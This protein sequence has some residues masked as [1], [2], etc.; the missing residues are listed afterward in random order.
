MNVKQYLE[1]IGRIEKLVHNK[2]LEAQKIRELCG[3]PAIQTDRERVQTSGISDPTARCAT[4][5]A[6]ISKQ[7]DRWLKKRQEIINQIDMIEDVGVYEVLEYRYVQQM[8]V[9][10]IAD[11]LEITEKQVWRRLGK[12]HNV[13]ESLYLTDNEPKSQQMSMDR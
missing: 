10:D 11:Q 4:E 2:Q 5:L 1:Q 8:S 12:A 3:N 9:I 6:S 7:I 13:F